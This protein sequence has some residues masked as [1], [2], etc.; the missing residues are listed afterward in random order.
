MDNNEFNEEN[1]NNY[2]MQ[3]EDRRKK[4]RLLYVAILIF[5]LLSITIIITYPYIKKAFTVEE[6]KEPEGQVVAITDKEDAFSVEIKRL[7]KNQYDQGKTK[8]IR[9]IL[10]EIGYNEDHIDN[11]ANDY[12]KIIDSIFGKIDDG[13]YTSQETLIIIKKIIDENLD[14]RELIKDLIKEL[15]DKGKK[16]KISKILEEIGYTPEEIK[17]AIDDLDKIIDLIEKKIDDGEYTEQEIIDIINK[18]IDEPKE[19]VKEDEPTKPD[20]PS[21]GSKTEID[22]GKQINVIFENIQL[23]QGSSKKDNP[24]LVDNKSINFNIVLDA[25][26]DYYAFTVDI[27][28]NSNIDVKVDNVA[29]NVLTEEQD[30]YLGFSLTYA[31][32]TKIN[33]DDVIKIGESKKIKFISLYKYVDIINNH[34]VTANYNGQITFVQK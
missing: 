6:K 2:Y 10:E 3:E 13:E 8:V 19:P 16:D 15:F 18:I 23:D 17:N 4:K 14:K 9:R 25:P 28:N 33:K 22:V 20:E 12:Q 31:D 29:S 32:G 11:T 34:D 5:L 27:K 1:E 24:I 7:T 21:G 26:G 30:K